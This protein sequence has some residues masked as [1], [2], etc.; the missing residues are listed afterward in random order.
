MITKKKID[1]LFEIAMAATS[2]E[3]KSHKSRY[4]WYVVG[5][6]RT[7]CGGLN[8]RDARYI[9]ALDPPSMCKLMIQFKEAL[10]EIDSLGSAFSSLTNSYNR[11]HE[12]NI[13]LRKTVEK[14]EA[15]IARLEDENKRLK[16]DVK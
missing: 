13:Q 15:K 1:R 16:E 9:A 2:G 5:L 7:I 10:E 8:E 11:E 12:Y 3:W 6:Y 14:H 4:H